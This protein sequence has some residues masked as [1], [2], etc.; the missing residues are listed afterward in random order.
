[1]ADAFLRELDAFRSSGGRIAWTVHNIL[2]H[3]TRYDDEETRLRA[4]VVERSDVVHVLTPGTADQVEPWFTI[5]PER[6]L[7]VDHPSYLGAYED[8][9]SRERARQELGIMPDEF[10][11]AVV[12]AIRPYKG[13]H[14]LLDAWDQL[15]P[16]AEPAR[17]L[18]IAGG[19]TEE[20]GVAEA[21]ERAALH[22]TVL[23]HGRQIPPSEIQHFLR[24]ADVAVLP[25][26]R[27][28]NSGAQMLALTFGLPVIVPAGGGLAEATNPAFARTFDPA[29]P[30]DLA[31]ALREA[32]DLA[33][34]AARAA[35]RAEAERRAP[36]PLSMRF[37]TELRARLESSQRQLAGVPR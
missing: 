21:M 22:P 10:V 15:D 13:L 24:A 23:L 12:G 11:Y 2:P 19:P 7:Q 1:M 18:L 4:G 17:R 25:Y 6:V 34:P 36:G 29:D 35:A 9:V 28:L 33:T 37:A 20:A 14:E 8:W 32:P 27:S 3:G 5:P 30:S 16:A 26:T 31:R